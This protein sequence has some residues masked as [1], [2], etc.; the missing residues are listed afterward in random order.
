MNIIALFALFC[1]GSGLSMLVAI[2]IEL[3][4]IR[5]ILERSSRAEHWR[6]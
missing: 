3:R 4:E 6:D 5:S 1:I 2:W